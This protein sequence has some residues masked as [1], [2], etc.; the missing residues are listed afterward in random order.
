M[1]ADL[2]LHQRQRMEAADRRAIRAAFV[3]RHVQVLDEQHAIEGA[4]I[5]LDTRGPGF[6]ALADR[7]R[8]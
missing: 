2:A 6:R 3:R 1:R 7:M 8:D 4:Q 5:A